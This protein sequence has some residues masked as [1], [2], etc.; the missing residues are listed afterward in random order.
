MEK[1][2]VE[3]NTKDFLN[4]NNKYVLCEF[5]RGAQ[6]ANPKD[7]FQLEEVKKNATAVLSLVDNKFEAE[8]T[9]HLRSQMEKHALAYMENGVLRIVAIPYY[10][11]TSKRIK[12]EAQKIVRKSSLS[13]AEKKEL[14]V[15][16]IGTNKSKKILKNYKTKNIDEA[17]I[18]CLQEIHDMMDQ[19]ADHLRQETQTLKQSES[20]QKMATLRELLPQFNEQAEIPADIYKIE[21]IVSESELAMI[22]GNSLPVKIKDKLVSKLFAQITEKTLTDFSKMNE[23]NKK[24]WSV[25]DFM[26]AIFPIK[27]INKGLLKLAQEKNVPL[28]FLKVIVNRF[29]EKSVTSQGDEYQKTQ[30]LTLK[31]AA[32]LT[33]LFLLLNSLKFE[34]VLLF[35]V[36]GIPETEL[37]KK[38]R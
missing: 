6:E 37:L 29:Y 33:V 30:K 22:D 10:F 7:V 17:N 2:T 32:H 8:A 35:S 36:L 34:L 14:V 9:C 38:L 26:L 5:L 15:Q 20:S 21:S 16:E 13:Y 23:M 4:N 12:T 3:I 28:G 24:L 18:A 11:P 25:L 31:F 19:R 1:Q 27:K